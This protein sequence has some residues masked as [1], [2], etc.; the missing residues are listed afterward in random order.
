M[1][2]A[3]IVAALQLSP[4]PFSGMPTGGT[5]TVAMSYLKRAKEAAGG[6]ALERVRSLH[7]QAR[8]TVLGVVGPG[9]E[10]DD[11][12]TGHFLQV[13]T[14]GPISLRQGY[15]GTDA[16]TQDATGLAHVNDSGNDI[17]TAITQ[18]YT[19]SFS[20]LFPQRLPG[21]SVFTGKKKLGNNTYNVIRA[22]PR[23]GYPIDLWLDSATFLLGREV[24]TFSPSRSAVSDFSDYRTVDG[25]VLPF[26]VHFQ[27]SQGNETLTEIKH[28][29]LN[30]DVAAK[31]VMPTSEPSDFALAP[32]TH[33]TT[34]PIEVINNHIYLDA[35][36]DGKG[37]YRFI[38]DTGGQGVLNPD[39]AAS[40]GIHGV[41]TFQAGGAG[42]GTVQSGFAW[43]PKLQI[44]GATLTHQSFAILP[45]GPVMQA[46][47]GVHIDG[48]V[49]YETVAR[50]LTTIDYAHKTMTLSLPQAGVRPPG[51]AVPFVFYQTI[52]QFRGTVD[53]L[54]GTFEVDTGSRGSLTLMSPFVASHDLAKKYGSNVAG[55]TGYGIGGASSSQVTRIKA[56]TIGSVDVPNVITN[57]STDTMGAMADSSVAGNLGGGVLKRFTVTFDYRNQ[58]MY[59]Q[60]NADFAQT[61]GDRSGLVIAA[62]KAGI[63]VLGVLTSTPAAQAGLRPRDLIM[64]VNGVDA[65]KLGLVRIRQLLSGPPGT[66]VKLTVTTGTAA[67][68]AVTLTL[69]DYV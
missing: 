32:G 40:L 35:R 46:I 20:Y 55:I 13:A 3:I 66:T 30:K 50:Y 52:P 51:T 38:F 53:G 16:W 45:L 59:L 37:P 2:I 58:I 33:S 62:V 42:A 19:T 22:L 8:L 28:I 54:N 69:K 36:V 39:V 7:V 63:R 4:P 1:F 10:W 47:E 17:S 11:L 57:L 56:L 48:M 27:D 15:N 23:G 5:P 67:A 43:V 6:D 64:S 24:V 31:F 29:D 61:E 25:V 65:S 12:V 9:D 26:K 34:F 68:R 14:L 44:G 60:R 21:T 49:G 18:A 41:G